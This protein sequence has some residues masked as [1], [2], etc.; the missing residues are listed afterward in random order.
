AAPAAPSAPVPPGAA[1]VPFDVR[2]L[3]EVCR[4]SAADLETPAPPEP[5]PAA[6]AT[7]P[8]DATATPVAAFVT[9]GLL[10]PGERGSGLAVGP[11]G[12]LLCRV[13]G[14]MILRLD[15]GAAVTGE[16]EFAAA[17]RRVRGRNTE[18]PL[19]GET[20][21]YVVR[22]AGAVLSLP[23]GRGRFVA[24]TL[25]DDIVYVREEAVFGFS[26]ELHWEAGRIPGLAA[27]CPMLQLRGRGA[28]ALWIEGTL[29]PVKLERG[30]SM[31]VDAAA[32]YGWVGR[33]VPHAL[34]VP[35]TGGRHVGCT[36]EGVLLLQDP[37]D[38]PR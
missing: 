26:D 9:R 17:V 32:L 25:D 36:G 30:Q 38:T 4:A 5:E 2:L 33:V 8:A 16:L 34:A 28:L 13:D 29:T 11:S 31:G 14:T 37:G 3:A 19:G 7:P 12:A 35:G 10:D 20:P 27:A 22:G 18:E 21:L 23:C 1:V 24:L 6:A 15:R